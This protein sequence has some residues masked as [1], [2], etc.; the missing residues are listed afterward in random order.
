MR[1]VLAS[2]SQFRSAILTAMGFSFEA[3]APEFHEVGEG[4]PQELARAFAEGKARSLGHLEDAWVVGAD[5]TLELDGEALRKPAS[6]EEMHAQLQ[7]LSGH[8]H[9]L[10][11]A[12]FVLRTDD[13]RSAARLVTT[14][15]RMR[16]LSDAEITQYLALDAPHGAVGS[17]LYEQRGRLLF[18]DVVGSDDSAIVGLPV[19]PLFSALRGLG[20]DAFQALQDAG[21]R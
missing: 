1:L 19:V 4:S 6:P 12:L 3:R 16:T 5:Q 7:R 10:H 15:L 14:R 13:G 2:T 18:D 17:Y 21:S 9:A 8:E 20:F 11:S